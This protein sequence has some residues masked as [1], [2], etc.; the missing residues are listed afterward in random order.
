MKNVV[1]TTIAVLATV[2]LFVACSSSN[3][4]ESPS[5][6]P[7]AEAKAKL[8][9]THQGVDAYCEGG[10]EAEADKEAAVYTTLTFNEDGSFVTEHKKSEQE[11]IKTSGKYVI[12]GERLTLT[13][14]G[15]APSE[16]IYRLEGDQL[17]LSKI[18]EE[19]VCPEGQALIVKYLRVVPTGE[20]PTPTP[21]PTPVEEE[22]E[23]QP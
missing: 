8:I 22:T 20:V 17:S 15:D 3:N 4:G 1:N 21:T 9:G 5:T 16:S 7:N 23:V 2:S 18:S 11:A 19:G 6:D 14:E 10:N 13:P 12:D